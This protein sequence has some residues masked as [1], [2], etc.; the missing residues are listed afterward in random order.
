VA[1]TA[2][3]FTALEYRELAEF[4]HHIRR[5]L[6]F[7]EEAARKSGLEPQ[8]HQALLALKGLPRGARPTIGELARRLFLRHHSA[9]EL[10]DRMER[11]GLA[12]REPGRDD[13][14]QVLVR[15][16]PA[17]HRVLRKLSLAH[18]A[19]LQVLGPDLLRSL[20]ALLRQAKR[21]EAA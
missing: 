7:S 8:Q 15:V 1:E 6:A 18:R 14:R 10:V 5:F 2:S 11:A 20:R 16:A 19:E 12:V 9:A 21:T 3:D 4:R 17:G 13:A